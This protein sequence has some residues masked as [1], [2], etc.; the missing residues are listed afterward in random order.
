M[1]LEEAIAKTLNGNPTKE[2]CLRNYEI[3]SSSYGCAVFKAPVTEETKNAYGM[4]HGGI[5]FTLMDNAAG[6]S[7][8][9]TGKKCVTLN[10][11]VNYIGAANKGNIF[12]DAKLT[13][14]GKSTLVINVEVRD[15]GERLIANGSFT[16]FVLGKII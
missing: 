12:A 6:Y 10:S 14:E 3:V 11:N 5:I 2:V 15:D 9:L 7:A 8:L 16:M 1:T 13:H 4:V